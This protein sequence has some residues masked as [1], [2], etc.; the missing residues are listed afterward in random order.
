MRQF[1]VQ[2]F[3]TIGCSCEELSCI[4]PDGRTD[5]LTDSIVYSLFEYTKTTNKFT[6]K[7]PQ[8]PIAVSGIAT[9]VFSVATRNGPCIDKPQPLK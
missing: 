6:K 8:L 2:N 4:R 9:I 5:T 3:S 7:Q 1:C